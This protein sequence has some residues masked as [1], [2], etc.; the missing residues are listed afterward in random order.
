MEQTHLNEI[1]HYENLLKREPMVD[2]ACQT[3]GRVGQ[4]N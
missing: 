2:M 1:K 3:D 4:L